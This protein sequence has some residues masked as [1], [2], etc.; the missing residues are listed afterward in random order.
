[1]STRAGFK[2]Q[3]MRMQAAEQEKRQSVTAAVSDSARVSESE[4][5][6]MPS[7]G[8]TQLPEV[9]AQVLQVGT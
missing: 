7:A 3:L 4:A 5:I 6:S 9:P 8:G 2:Q 1:M